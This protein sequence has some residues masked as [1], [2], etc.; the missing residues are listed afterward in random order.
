M[1]GRDESYVVVVGSEFRPMETKSA[2]SGR[3]ESA[4]AATG[5]FAAS[6]TSTAGAV[7][8]AATAVPAATATA[9]AAATTPAATT[10]TGS[11]LSQSRARVKLT[12]V[13]GRLFYG[14]WECLCILCAGIQAVRALSFTAALRLVPKNLRGETPTSLYLASDDGEQL[15]SSA[16][17]ICGQAAESAGY[18]LSYSDPPSATT[19]GVDQSAA[20]V[21][22][23]PRVL[24]VRSR[25]AVVDD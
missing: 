2:D 21:S 25:R 7:G 11:A 3:R 5:T 14:C 10:A 6:S 16:E 22:C 20:V 13:C 18:G 15:Q 9:A 1:K 23:A 4:G 12:S 17:G 19:S 8:S 24:P